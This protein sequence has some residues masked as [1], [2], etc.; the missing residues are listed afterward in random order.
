MTKKN[1]GSTKMIILV[2]IVVLATIAI[3]FLVIN[4]YNKNGQFSNQYT[5]SAVVTPYQ[6][7][8][9]G[10]SNGNN[11]IATNYA[12]QLTTAT[13]KIK[14]GLASHINLHLEPLSVNTTNPTEYTNSVTLA[15]L[16]VQVNK[17]VWDSLTDNERK[18]LIN[19][20]MDTLHFSDNTPEAFIITD[21]KGNTIATGHQ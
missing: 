20:Y 7:N 11:T 10:K 18:K 15:R 5:P 8:N 4:A 1:A 16:T 17:N 9:E 21:T 14:P 6:T 3:A 2:S 13:D 19:T 12:Q